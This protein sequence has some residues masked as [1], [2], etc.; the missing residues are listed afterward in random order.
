[1]SALVHYQAGAGRAAST[2]G[3]NCAASMA[4]RVLQLA[5]PLMHLAITLL[6]RL[7]ELGAT[8]F[9]E[10]KEADEVDGLEE[11]VDAWMEGLWAPLAKAYAA[12]KEVG[13]DEAVES[14]SCLLLVPAGC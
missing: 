5:G 8:C 4:S 11:G 10:C 13:A 6:C 12:L 3:V 7:S 9:Y 14:W 2:A 1:M